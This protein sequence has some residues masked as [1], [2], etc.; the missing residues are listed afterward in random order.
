MRT[1]VDDAVQTQRQQRP[2]EFVDPSLILKVEMTGMSMEDDWE[3]VGLR[4]LSSDDDNTLVLFS[5]NEELTDFRRK[6]AAYEG[7]KPAG[8]VNRSFA[9]FIDRIESVSTL[10]PKDRLGIRLM[11]RGFTD[12]TDFQDNEIYLVDIE[13]WDFAGRD[14]RS[15][16]ADEIS[17]FIEERNGEVFDIYV[18]PSLTILRAQAPGHSLRPILSVPEVA[19]V[20]HPPEPDL[21]AQPIVDMAL[22]DLPPVS[23]V[24][25]DAP[26]VAILD[27]GINAHPLLDDVLIATEAF[28][29]ELQTADVWGHGTKVGGAAVFGDLREQIASGSLQKSVRLVSAKI[30]TDQGQFYERRTLPNQMRTVLQSLNA[31]YGCRI[32]V[33]S[34]GDNKSWFERGRVGPWAMTLDELARDLDVLVFVSAGNRPPRGGNAVEQAVT[35]Y[36]QYLLEDANR[37]YEPSGAAN[38][39]TVGAVAHGSG[40]SPIHRDD[41][42]VSAIT[43]ERFEPSPF[44]RAGPGGGG[45]AKPDFVDFGGTMVFSAVTRSLQTAP[46]LPEAGIATL[47]H[48]FVRQLFTSSS[49]TSISTPLLARKAALLLQRFPNA[50]ANLIRALLAGAA[51]VP[52]E[53]SNRLRAMDT[54]ETASIIG[55]GFIDPM[56]AAYSD[57]HRVIYFAEDILDIDRFAIY[58]IPIPAEFQTGG[59]RTIRVSLAYDP[60]VR[61]TRAEYLGTKMDFRLIRGC[62]PQ[63]ISD[64]FRSHVGEDTEHPEMADRYDCDLKPNKTHRKGNTLQTGSITFSKDTL[65]YGNEYHLVVRCIEGW[66]T[67]ELRQ[68]FAVVVELEHQAGV[69][70]YARL[71]ARAR[72]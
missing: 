59:K 7:P 35:Q 72:V 61:R 19:I 20:D 44:T 22:G 29:P 11:E 3:G 6:L 51:S 69:Q 37:I 33:L 16:K 9:G 70:L 26:I 5:S 8:Q 30:I 23:P 14:A 52:D 60:P 71:R 2:P 41:A 50:S 18:G 15:R 63:H 31:R 4:L 32:F 13:L 10:E 67:D 56:K 58:R 24:S 48:D 42:H 62:P 34:L 47:N 54:Q 38:V 40:L 36:P 12:V 68:R 27:S 65:D 66:A 1:E 57:D 25:P 55:N 64:H 39:V 46:N 21:A 49:G 17:A 43:R 45:V 53:T 28:P